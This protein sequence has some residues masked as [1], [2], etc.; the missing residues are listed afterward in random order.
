MKKLMITVLLLEGLASSGVQ[1]LAV[2]QSVGFVGASV[3]TMSIVVA[4]FLL[5]LALGYA[6]GGRK[7]QSDARKIL[8]RN[9]TISIAILGGG[10]SYGFVELFYGLLNQITRDMGSVLNNP[11]LHLGFFCTLIMGPL[12]YLLAQTVPLAL[13]EARKSDTKGKSAGDATAISTLGNVAGCLI[14]GLVLLYWFGAA[15][16]IFINC[17]LLATCLLILVSQSKQKNYAQGFVAVF[18]LA[19]TY[20]IN[21]GL[22]DHL[23]L[24]SNAYADSRVVPTDEGRML[25]I[26]RS[27]ASFV[28]E[29]DQSGWGY[30]EEIKKAL[31]TNPQNQKYLVL[32]AGGFSLTAADTK[33]ALDVTYVDVDP[34][35]KTVAEQS[36]LKRPLNGEFIV[37]DARAFLLKNPLP[38]W[39]GIVVDVFSNASQIPIHLS[40]TE[41]MQLV[42]SRLAPGGLAVLNVIADP[43]M[44]DDYSTRM[45][46][47]IRN[48]FSRC[49]TDLVQGYGPKEA[50]ILYFCRSLPSAGK[51]TLLS[52]YS[53]DTIQ[54][55]IDSYV[56]S[57]RHKK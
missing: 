17:L 52:S 25:I 26:N 34:D 57:L 49:V 55:G 22:S 54:S 5:F 53:D 1:M 18:V 43:T 28:K 32:G 51:P 4:S 14:T 31:F 9:L 44:T 21:V 46:A 15:M 23:F 27:P 45:D 50:N 33:G 20:E 35:L 24:S 29:A 10:F 12:I 2:R 7:N 42:G 3:L 30:V 40:T 13:S 37:S 39:N 19:V 8:A 47:T 36:F 48:S 56:A 11:L 41:F 16:A 38:Q 6:H